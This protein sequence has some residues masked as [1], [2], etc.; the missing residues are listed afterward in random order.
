MIVLGKVVELSTPVAEVLA[1]KEDVAPVVKTGA[2]TTDSVVLL[3]LLMCLSRQSWSLGFQ[4]R[5]S[6]FLP[7]SL[8]HKL[9]LS[10]F[11]Y[12]CPSY[13]IL[14]HFNLFY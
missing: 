8:S 4:F 6:L 5:R 7:C 1:P 2:L 12:L 9:T 3:P 14:P 10:L 13:F 11:Y